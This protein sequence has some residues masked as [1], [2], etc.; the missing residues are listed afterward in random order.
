M[1]ELLP[2]PMCGAEPDA[3]EVGNDHTKKRSLTIKC[4]KCRVQIT[5][6]AMRFSMEWLHEISANQWN[7]RH[8]PDGW[9][10]VPVE[11][12][13]SMRRAGQHAKEH[14]CYIDGI[15]ADLLAAAPKPGGGDE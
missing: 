3:I 7:C 15:Y 8:T 4:P 5:N 2:C 9:Q 1:S 10:L 6:S 12:T 13:P 11:P 14:D